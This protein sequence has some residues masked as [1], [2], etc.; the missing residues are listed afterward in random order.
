[1]VF[2]LAFIISYASFVSMQ[3]MVQLYSQRNGLCFSLDFSTINSYSYGESHPVFLGMKSGN[4]EQ[5]LAS[6]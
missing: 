1:M 4:F 3:Y 6:V 5:H 2:L